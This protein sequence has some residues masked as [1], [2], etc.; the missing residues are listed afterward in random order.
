MNALPKVSATSLSEPEPKIEEAQEY[1][2]IM[3][4]LITLGVNTYLMR[5]SGHY[6]PH[7]LRA[8]I[9]MVKPKITYVIHTKVFTLPL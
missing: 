8:I 9:N 1:Q 3:N 2:I 5:V 7:E 6:Y 4:W